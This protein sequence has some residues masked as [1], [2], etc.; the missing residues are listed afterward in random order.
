MNKVIYLVTVTDYD[1]EYPIAP[2]STKEK[3]EEFIKKEMNE[4]HEGNEI[5]IISYEVD[6]PK[7]D[8]YS[9]FIITEDD[10][11]YLKLFEKEFKDFCKSIK[12]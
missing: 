8:D 5:H 10:K 3:A 11:K 6:N 9:F 7:Y 12:E 2:F 4:L 1:G